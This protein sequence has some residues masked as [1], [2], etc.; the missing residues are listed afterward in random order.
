MPNFI[1]S[2]KRS[3]RHLHDVSEVQLIETHIS[4]VLLTGKVVYKV[5]KPVDLGF[6]DFTTL[7]KR[8]Y[9]SQIRRR[10]R[11][12]VLQAAA[13]K[14]HGGDNRRDRL[15]SGFFYENIQY[16]HRTGQTGRDPAGRQYGHIARRP[17]GYHGVYLLQ[18][19]KQRFE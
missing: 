7:E 8:R 11:V 10:N 18:A 9:Y 4:W 5:K 13:E 15:R 12:F 3:L 14:Q 19:E 6:V 16:R 1:N 2:L 17:S